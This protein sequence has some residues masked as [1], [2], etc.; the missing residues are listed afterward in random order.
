[1][2]GPTPGPSQDRSRPSSACSPFPSWEGLVVGSRTQSTHGD[3][4]IFSQESGLAMRFAR[5]VRIRTDK[6]VADIDTLEGARGLVKTSPNG[7]SVNN[8]PK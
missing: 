5:I 1:M 6:S 2:N 4:R 3:R 7:N 8:S